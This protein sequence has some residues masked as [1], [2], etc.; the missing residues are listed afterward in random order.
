LFS[1]RKKIYLEQGNRLLRD[2]VLNFRDPRTIPRAFVLSTAAAFYGYM[3][4]R[5]MK[6][7]SVIVE[8]R[9]QVINTNIPP[10]STEVVRAVGDRP[11]IA[12]YARKYH[13][14]RKRGL[15]VDEEETI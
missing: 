5:K 15:G 7:G 10:R 3:T 6:F 1:F 13:T 4:Y 12:I 2:T 8:D 9:K 14:L 11:P